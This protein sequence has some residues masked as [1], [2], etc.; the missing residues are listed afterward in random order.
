MKEPSDFRKPPKNQNLPPAVKMELEWVYGYRAKDS[1]NNIQIM[2]DGALAYNAAALGVIYNP[3]DHSQRFFNMH[4]DDV[5][6]IA[7]SPDLQTIA[8]GEIGPKPIIQV[9]DAQSMQP[10][11][12]LKGKLTKGIENIA[13]SP[14][15]KVLV[16]VAIDDDHCVAAYNM[17]TGACLGS[18]KGDKSKIIEIA[19]KSDTEFATAGV[20]HFMNWSI[21]GGNLVSKRGSF[22][23]NDQRIGSVK[24]NKDNALTGC[25]TGEMFI[26]GGGSISK[27]VKLHERPLDA[28]HV[29][30]QY[31][32]TG[33]RDGKV[34]V[35]SNSYAILFQIPLSP[36][37]F[38]SVST[39]VRALCLNEAANSLVI[40][41]FGS[42]IFQV[43][44]DMQKKGI[45][46]PKALIHG[47]FSPAKKDNNEAWGMAAFSQK[48]QVVSVSDDGTL[49]V[50]D[51][52]AKKLIQTVD[53]NL[54]DKGQPLPVDPA[55][56]ELPNGA[57]GRSVCVSKN[58]KYCAVGFRDGSYRLYD[59]ASWKMMGAIQNLS[60]QW[61]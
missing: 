49:R 24:F 26:W 51:T 11:F 18:N 19:M 40:G 46:A 9:W 60:K 39:E 56:K 53:L 1:K 10:K 50:W 52:Q 12:T 2:K 28:I 27:A 15:G 5:T 14:S 25:F 6:A 31:V 20:K 23:Q 57:K 41:T 43:P 30:S 34:S 21:S 8:T 44:I 22:G 36:Q 58:G 3:A 33:G 55:T 7:F 4:N 37:Q 48:D 29:H 32:L 17:D 38:T 45:G 47:H 16:A 42:E 35:L 54:N 13:F 59:V 61:I